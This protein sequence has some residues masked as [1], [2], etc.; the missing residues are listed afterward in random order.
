MHSRYCRIEVVDSFSVE[1]PRSAVL[2]AS[3]GS[4]RAVTRRPRALDLLL[5]KDEMFTLRSWRGASWVGQSV[6]SEKRSLALPLCICGDPCVVLKNTNLG[7]TR[8]VSIPVTVLTRCGD[9]AL[10]LTARLWSGNCSSDSNRNIC[11]LCHPGNPRRARLRW[12]LWACFTWIVGTR[13][14][15]VSATPQIRLR[16]YQHQLWRP[17]W[18]PCWGVSGAKP[19]LACAYRVCPERIVSSVLAQVIWDILIHDTLAL[20]LNGNQFRS[21]CHMWPHLF[22]ADWLLPTSC[23][24]KRFSAFLNEKTDC[25]WAWVSNWNPPIFYVKIKNPL[26]KKGHDLPRWGKCDV[27]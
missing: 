16:Y 8:L 12:W 24:Q 21:S 5:C 2:G 1:L 9:V 3:E 15:L 19:F 13:V 17:F 26:A 7:A 20:S 4:R 25:G 23:P 10:A 11:Y 22:S 27:L 6:W 14:L 18:L